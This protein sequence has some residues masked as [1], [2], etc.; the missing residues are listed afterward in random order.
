LRGDYWQAVVAEHAIMSH[1]ASFLNYSPKILW[2]NYVVVK[3]KWYMAGALVELNQA[4]SS[5]IDKFLV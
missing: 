1:V 2:K 4:T 3:E 5:Q